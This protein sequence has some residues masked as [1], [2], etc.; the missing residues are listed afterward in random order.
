[1]PALNSPQINE[2]AR[3]WV[4]NEQQFFIN[5]KNE[6]RHGITQ[7]QSGQ[8]RWTQGNFESRKR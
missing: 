5:E 6:R 3:G 4:L 1:M 7:E 8:L 2:E